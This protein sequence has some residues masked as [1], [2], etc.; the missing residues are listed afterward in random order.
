MQTGNISLNGSPF[1][2]GAGSLSVNLGGTSSGEYGALTGVG[3][4]TLGGLLT[5][6]LTNG[7][8]PANG[9]TFHILS[10]SSLSGTLSP[11]NIPSGF[12]VS[13]SNSGVYLTV[14]GAVA[15]APAITVQPTNVTVPYAGNAAFSVAATGMTPL[16]YQ[17]FHNGAALS[18]GGVVSG[19][20]SPRLRAKRRHG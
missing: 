2:Q 20:G 11:L 6:T 3:S 5:V 9:N 10:S 15:L 12:S 14:T 8:V 17:W 16:T 19:S 1:A 4:A 18:D 13:Y 7:F